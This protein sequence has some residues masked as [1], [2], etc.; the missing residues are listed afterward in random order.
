M[1]GDRWKAGEEIL[2]LFDVRLS[3]NH[4]FDLNVVFLDPLSN[5]GGLKAG[6]FMF[7]GPGGIFVGWRGGVGKLG[8]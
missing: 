6:A 5:H 8:T 4:K 7:L 1:E 2:D 3:G